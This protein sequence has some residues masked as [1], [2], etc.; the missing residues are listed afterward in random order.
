MNDGAPRPTLTLY[1]ICWCDSKVEEDNSVGFKDLIIGKPSKLFTL[2][3]LVASQSQFR[4][5]MSPK[6]ILVIS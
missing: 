2:S 5:Q 6:D 3:S 1:Q 4:E